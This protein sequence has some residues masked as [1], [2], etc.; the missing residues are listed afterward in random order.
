[1]RTDPPK[2]L[3]RSAKILWRSLVADYEISDAGGLALVEAAAQAHARAAEARAEIKR[4][5]I[6]VQDRFGQPKPHPACAIERDALSLLVR[7]IRALALEPDDEPTTLRG[8]RA[9]AAARAATG[10]YA[11]GTPPLAL[12]K[13]GS[14]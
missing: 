3:A 13:G 12:A 7:A 2:Y 11:P 9:A 4:D 10:K 6:T 5:G 8:Q 14:K 1:M